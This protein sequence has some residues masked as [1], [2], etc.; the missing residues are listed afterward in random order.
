MVAVCLSEKLGRLPLAEGVV[1]RLIDR[2]RLNSE[3]RC[4]VAVDGEGQH[5]AARLLIRGDVA[6]HR[7]LLQFSEYLRSPLVELIDVGILQRVLILSARLAAAYV[8][9]LCGLQEQRRA[10]NLGQ[11]GPQAGD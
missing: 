10:R 9:I 4:L 6:Q 8:E 7:E 5:A 2:R 11:L 1:K 3:A